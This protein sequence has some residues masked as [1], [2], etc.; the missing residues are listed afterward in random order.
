ME[1]AN[2]KTPP[3]PEAL[4]ETAERIGTPTYAYVEKRLRRQCERLRTLTHDL[5]ARLLYAVKANPN[6]A[7]LRVM[8]SEGLGLDVVS[9]GERVLAERLGFAPEQ[10]LFTANNLTDAEM[11]AAQES[12]V[13]LAFPPKRSPPR[14]LWPKRTTC[15][16][17]VSTSTSG[18][19]FETW[20]PSSGP[21]ASY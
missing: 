21:C 6:P 5:P 3:A 13:L 1:P 12:G 7:V 20:R 15:A 11:R 8:R 9:P 4:R 17:S 18:A 14:G 2:P 10:V 19:A 16:W